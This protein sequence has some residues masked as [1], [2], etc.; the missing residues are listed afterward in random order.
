MW[1]LFTSKQG[2]DVT[3]LVD[4]T[5]YFC[6]HN[7]YLLL[8]TQLILVFRF[9]CGRKTYITYHVP[10]VVK[11]YRLDIRI[12]SLAKSS[13]RN[14]LRICR[15]HHDLCTLSCSSLLWPPLTS[16]VHIL[17]SLYTSYFYF[18]VSFLLDK[19]IVQFCMWSRSGHVFFLHNIHWISFRNWIAT[20]SY[21]NWKKTLCVWS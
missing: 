5:L 16:I 13:R 9:I 17:K 8:V 20:I 7:N 1:R 18:E 21:T 14:R 10:F 15:L 2:I 3:L 6:E 4:I 19:H 11:W 12:S